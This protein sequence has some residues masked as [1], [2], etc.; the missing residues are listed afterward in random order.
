LHTVHAWRVLQGGVLC[1][2]GARI[3]VGLCQVPNDLF[4]TIYS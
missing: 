2:Q 4:I 3:T 1:I